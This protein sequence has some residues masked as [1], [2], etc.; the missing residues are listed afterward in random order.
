MILS[1]LGKKFV[2][3]LTGLLL[4]GF[5]ITHLSGNLLIFLGPEALNAYAQKLRD[6]GPMLWAARSG[7]LLAA[8]LHIWFSIK[9]TLEN[10]K[11]RPISYREKKPLQSTW[12]GRTMILSGMVVLGF[13]VYHLLH[14]TFGIANPAIAHLVDP[15]QRPD[16]YS[17]VIRGFQDPFVALGYSA[18]L[19]LLGLHLS[20]GISSSLQ[21]LGLNNE[22][23]LLIFSKAGRALAALITLGYISIPLSILL[24]WVRLP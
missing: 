21:S 5:L 1:S 20:H 9:L 10:K 7:L 24:G 19:A 15:L 11:A 14:F 22:K 13:I 6:L 8:V 16:V 12:A 4:L 2:V 23:T 17:M 18:A 3:A